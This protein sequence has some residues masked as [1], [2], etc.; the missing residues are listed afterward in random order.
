MNKTKEVPSWF[1]GEIYQKG[2]V[3]KNPYS[4][5]TMELDALELS[6]YDYIIG[7]NSIIQSMGGVMDPRTGRFQVE[8]AKGLSW[9]R[10]NNAEAYMVLL[11]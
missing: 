1:T 6:I 2:K 7:L 11:D 3:V 10:N 4:G 5:R 9:F 8:M